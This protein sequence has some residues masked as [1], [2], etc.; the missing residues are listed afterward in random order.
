MAQGMMTTKYKGRWSGILLTMIFLC[1]KSLPLFSDSGKWVIA[2][3]KFTYTKGQTEG[4]VQSGIT[5]MIPSS[6]LENLNRSLQRNVMPDEELARSLYKLRSERQSLY[7]QLSSEYKKRDSLVLSNYTDVKLKSALKDEEKKIQELQT[8]IDNNLKEVKKQTENSLYKNELL[9]KNKGRAVEKEKL[10][11]FE[12]FQNLFKNIFVKDKNLYTEEDVSFYRN[13][14]S[15][16]FAPSEN[17]K[18]E[19]VYS[20]VFEKEV[21]S[22]GINSLII[23]TITAYGDYMSVTAELILYP[24]AKSAGQVTELGSIQDMDFITSSIAMQ[25]LPLVTNAMPVE[26]QVEIGPQAAAATAEIY[27]DDVLQSD[28]TDVFILDSGVHTIQ[29]ISKNYRTAGTSYYFEGNRKYKVNVNFEELK[30]GSLLI[31][32]KKELEGE[33]YANSEKAVKRADGKSQI[34][35]DGKAILGEFI[36]E[37]GES[38]FFYIPQKNVLDG[39]YAII[40]PKPTDRMS[41]IDTRRKW[42]YGAYSVF[43]I[44]LIPGFYANGEFRNKA[45]LYDQGQISY[46]EANAWQIAMNVTTGLSIACGLFWGYELIRY[47]LAANSVLPQNARKGKAEAL[48]QLPAE[49]ERSEAE[50][51][52]KAES[53]E[54]AIID[55]DTKIDAES[56]KINSGEKKK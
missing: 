5:Q 15:A 45:K 22:A 25:L 27:I 50:N 21:F 35:I 44:S 46:S 51:E 2:A 19:G 29:F 40:N 11:E 55:E 12:K 18:A 52:Q 10:S 16:M 20:G 33:I 43:M 26:L 42:M 23:G 34:S 36:A 38:S 37:N 39:T 17:A 4:S 54:N 48:L 3:Q 1:C 31:G 32:L 56:E 8:K 49:D 41:Y 24:G 6:I 7:L 14:I 30:A 13:D 47:L 9:E 28:D 53:A